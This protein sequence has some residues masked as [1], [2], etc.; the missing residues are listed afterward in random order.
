MNSY[1]Q[2]ELTQPDANFQY[3]DPPFGNLQ[4]D[5]ITRPFH[6]FEKVYKDFTDFWLISWERRWIIMLGNIVSV[7]FSALFSSRFFCP[8]SSLGGGSREEWWQLPGGCPRPGQW[9][10]Q[11][12]AFPELFHLFC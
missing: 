4:L 8:S 11:A 10:V 1:V 5:H 3:S 7:Y 6:S 12:G 2:I 9:P